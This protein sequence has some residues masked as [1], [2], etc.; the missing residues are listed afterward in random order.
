MKIEKANTT[1]FSEWLE[2]TEEYKLARVSDAIDSIET[3]LNEIIDRLTEL[4][5][6]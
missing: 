3:K 4:G 5:Y 6:N 2:L 1:D